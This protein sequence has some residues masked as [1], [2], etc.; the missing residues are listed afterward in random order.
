MTKTS[1]E[2]WSF[3]HWILFVICNLIIGAWLFGFI[4][5]GFGT[6]TIDQVKTDEKEGCYFGLFREGAPANMELI[7]SFERKYGKKPV[8]VMWFIDWSYDFPVKECKKISSYSS[9][10]HVVWEPWYWGEEGKINLDKIIRGE[11]DDY[12]RRWAKDAAAYK[13][14]LFLRWGHE[15]NIEKYPWGVPNNNKDPDKY[16]KAYRHIHNIFK[17]AGATNVKWVWCFNNYPNPDEEWNDYKKAYPGDEYVDWIGID[18]YNWG[19]TQTWSGWQSFQEMLRDQVREAF[20][21]YKKPI[22][23]PEFAS[24]EIGGDKAS[25][26]KDILPSLKISMKQ[27]KSLVWF[28]IKKETD[29]RITSSQKSDA[30]FKSIIK[31]PYFLTSAED[32]INYTVPKIEEV[33]KIATAK[34]VTSVVK[35]DGKLNEWGKAIPANLK[36][37]SLLQEGISWNGPQDLSGTIYIM[38]DSDNLYLAASVTDNYPLVN[39]K[40]RGDIWN[41]D[42]VEVC[43]S[44][45]PNADPKREAFED[46]DFQIGFG[47]GDGKLNKPSI[48]IWQKKRSPEG[49]EIVVV[50]KKGGYN[51]EAKIPWHSFTDFRPRAGTKVSFDVALDDAD[52]D[53]RKSQLVFS[54]DYAFYRDPSVWGILSFID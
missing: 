19:A 40:R 13:K 5:Y 1:F 29:W 15:F 18:G 32:L 12:I 2:F 25:W 8:Q 4:A 51:L 36:D 35:I 48:W 21:R 10:P 38:W 6:K 54:G 53:I 27:V 41:G 7:K 22:M 37:R 52:K 9:I 14:P 3:G 46:G 33:K 24:T 49:S 39:F 17:S 50:K 26:I 31:D 16:I 23:I 47:T 28:N 34:R 43:L 44:T 11:F 42:A 20:K 30:A 45:N